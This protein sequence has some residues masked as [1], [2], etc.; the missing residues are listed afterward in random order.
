[1]HLHQLRVSS[2]WLIVAIGELASVS[3]AGLETAGVHLHQLRVSSDW[4]IVAIGALVSVSLA[5]LE[6]AGV[7]LHQL[8]E[9]SDCL[10]VLLAKPASHASYSHGKLVQ[11][12]KRRGW[13]EHT[14]PR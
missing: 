6:T 5:G 7:H 4:L 13:P 9:S 14:V 2:D 11:S 3:L 1:V 12:K 8:R 10:M